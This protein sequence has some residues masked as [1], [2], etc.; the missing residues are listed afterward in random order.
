MKARRIRYGIAA[1]LV[2]AV[3]GF[4]TGAAWADDSGSGKANLASGSV[5]GPG[6]GHAG[7]PGAQ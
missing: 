1:V 7:P 2:A 4:A 6:G 3:F 5:Y